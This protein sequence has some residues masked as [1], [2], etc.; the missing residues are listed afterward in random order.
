MPVLVL[1]ATIALSLLTLFWTWTRWSMGHGARVLLRGLGVILLIVGLYLSGLGNL[2]G[3]GLRSIYDWAQRTQ[4][5]TAMLVGFSLAGAGLVF[6][7]VGTLLRPRNRDQAKAVRQQ[8]RG[9]AASLSSSGGQASKRPAASAPAPAS[10]E[11]AEI[12]A[13]LDR[14]GIQ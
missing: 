2:A 7:V 10:D 4:M 5:S 6:W 9:S 1:V 14:R 11:D 12:A 3:N 13:I 8:R